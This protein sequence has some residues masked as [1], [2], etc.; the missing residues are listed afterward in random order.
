MLV[1]PLSTSQ[2]TQS[3]FN[4]PPAEES[5]DCLY[6]NVYAPATPAGGASKAVMFWIYGGALQFGNAGQDAYDGSSFAAYEDVVV[7]TANYRTNG[8]LLLK[9]QFW[10]F[11]LLIPY[12]IRFSCFTRAATN[13]TQPRISRSTIRPQL[14]AA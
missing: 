8:E 11:G 9:L 6:L 13:G 10:T 1:D 14:G 12:S 2:F 3:L 7:V 5:E 4:N